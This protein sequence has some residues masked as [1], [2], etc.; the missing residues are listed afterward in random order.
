[1]T[2][3]ADLLDRVQNAGEDFEW[4]PTTDKMIAAVAKHL[5]NDGYRSDGDDRPQVGSIMDI[6]AGDGRVLAKLA[7]RCRNTPHLYAIEKSSVLVQAQPENVI[8][9]G[10]DLYEQ[11]LA[12]LPV[13]VI[14]CN[15]PYSQFEVWATQII[16][17]GFAKYAYLVLPRRWTESAEIAAALKRRGATAKVIHK[18]DFQSGADRTARAVID[19]I[20]VSF[21]CRD[22]YGYREKPEDPF[23]L[24]F[25]QNVSTFDVDT[26]DEDA[27]SWNE[28]ESSKQR[29]LARLRNLDN[30]HDLVAAY[31]EEYARMQDNYRAIFALDLAILK[32]LGVQKNAVRDGLK[33]RMA[34]LKTKYWE[35]LFERLDTITSRLSSA[36]KKAMLDKLNARQSVAFTEN[37]AIAI[38][39]WAIKNANHYF[40]TQLVQLFRDLSTAEGVMNYKSNQRTWQKFGWR[41]RAEEFSHYALDYRIVIPH[42]GGIA[43]KDSFLHSYRAQGGLEER[44]HDLIADVIAVLSNLGFASHGNPSFRREWASNQWHDWHEAGKSAVLFQV[45]AFKNGNMHF[46][47]MPDAIKAVNV[48]AGR[49]L[50]WLHTREDVETE[51]GYTAEEAKRFFFST[52]L[53]APSSIRLLQGAVPDP[54]PEGVDGDEPESAPPRASVA[55]PAA[56]PTVEF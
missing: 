31:D 16:D 42:H 10:T 11:N 26:T 7:A 27:A 32:E 15:P 34:G 21:P 19:I 9:V 20:E 17:T 3:F 13:D 40:G 28:R 47:F 46:R 39:L 12:C 33:K 22:G 8:P 53:I 45:K 30:I 35:L 38:V 41:H 5:P 50:G 29:H 14:F 18:D 1:M 55:R 24:W 49:L 54:E 44:A 52:K 37:N 51:L 25:D 4:Y 48:E 56:I 43:E 36:S 6:G 23:D 2:A